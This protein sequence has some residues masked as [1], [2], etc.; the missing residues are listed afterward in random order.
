MNKYNLIVTGPEFLPE[1]GCEYSIY[2]WVGCRV[3]GGEVL[4]YNPDGVCAIALVAEAD[5]SVAPVG[6]P[7]DHKC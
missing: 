4:D 1:F 3:E 5:Q 7:A 6:S 2:E